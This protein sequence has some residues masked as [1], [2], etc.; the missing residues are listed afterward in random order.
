M[1][2]CYIV[3]MQA[4]AQPFIDHFGV[5][6]VKDFFSPLPC[7]LYRSTLSEEDGGAELNIVLN[8]QQHGSDLV[9]CEAAS[10]ATLSAIQKIDPD[11]IINS[12]TCGGFKSEGAS[13]AEVFI[14]NAVMFHDRRVPGDD[15]WGTQALGN[16]PV[17]EGSEALAKA[18]GFG[19]GK[20][21]TGS[22]LDMQPC[23]EKIIHENGGQLKDMEGAAVAFV[24][25]LF[26]K[27]ILFVKSVT[28]LCDSGAETF[29]EFSKNLTAA[30]ESLR[31]ANIKVI[32]YLAN[33]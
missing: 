28:D 11:I 29:E 32:K 19:M 20:V 22:S 24:C 5:E 14:G 7:K 15:A 26:Q 6:E 16:Y 12:G 30:S 3:A 18:L 2:I 8:G 23:D 9:G 17:W 25:S 10:V 1:K 31:Q 13:I 21:T 33:I 4:E 27:P